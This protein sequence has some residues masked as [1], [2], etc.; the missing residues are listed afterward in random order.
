MPIHDWS[1]VSAG[2]FHDFHLEWISSLKRVLNSGVLPAGYYALAEQIAGGRE[3]D[4]LALEDLR[5]P[6]NR[7]NGSAGGASSDAG[8][9]A[10]ATAPPQV[11][12]T[13]TAE[14]DRYAQKSKQ[15]AVRHASD[16][17]VV[18]LVEIVSPGNKD[19]TAAARDFVQKAVDF[20]DAGIHLLI[21]DLF[22]PTPRDPEGLH[23]LIW[24]HFGS[25]GFHLP[26]GE[27][28]TIV[29]YAAGPTK[30]AYIE[31]TAVGKSLPPMPLF[32]EP[33]RYVPLALQPSYDAAFAAVPKRWRDVLEA[34]S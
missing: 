14:S 28:L 18:A 6:G 11:R 15:I 21:L 13:A 23:P 27:P 2:I 5:P 31:P 4:V 22:P 32:Y 1:R 33:E 17:R 25:D 9:V 30:R 29:S 10:L 24:S 8:G 3:P 20:L 16:D 34:M 7:G 12:F 19:R 26:P